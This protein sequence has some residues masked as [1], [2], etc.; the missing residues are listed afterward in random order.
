M[1]M[2]RQLVFWMV[3]GLS[4]GLVPSSSTWAAESQYPSRPIRLI[5]AAAPGGPND[6][7]ARMIAPPWGELRGK[8]IVVDNRAGATGVIGTEMGARAAA[9]G[10][11]LTMGFPG[12]LI[13]APMLTDKPS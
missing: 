13:I 2:M 4:A 8:P 3:C 10:Y 6:I 7:A 9:D 5:V 12:P 1:A 11:T